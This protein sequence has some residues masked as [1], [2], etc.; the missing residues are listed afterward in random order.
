MEPRSL[1]GST[2]VLLDLSVKALADYRGSYGNTDW[3][4]S[5]DTVALMTGLAVNPRMAGRCIVSR[6]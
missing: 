5:S 4:L 2:K 6:S 1:Y 3:R